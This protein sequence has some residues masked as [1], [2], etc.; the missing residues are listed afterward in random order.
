M[1]IRLYKNSAEEI[2]V[3]KSPYIKLVAEVE[4]T[5]R[6]EAD[7]V[8]PSIEF[9]FEQIP[10]FNYAFIVEFNRWYFVS[11][12]ISIS[13]NMWE[14]SFEEDV[15]MSYKDGIMKLKGFIDRNEFEYDELIPDSKR[16]SQLGFDLTEVECDTNFFI[17]YTVTNPKEP[18]VII[19]G[20]G[21]EI[22]E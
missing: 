18:T 9:Y 17:D 14:V 3:D 20:F 13:L 21:L 19:N 1:T 2:V 5:L 6:D 12:V 4:G 11:G 15:L 7:I 22:K 16:V 10:S 8:S